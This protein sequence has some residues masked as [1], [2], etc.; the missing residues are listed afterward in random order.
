MF[1]KSQMISNFTVLQ[2]SQCFWLMKTWNCKLPQLSGM[3]SNTLRKSGAFSFSWCFLD[4]CDDWWSLL[5]IST[6]VWFQIINGLIFIQE[7]ITVIVNQYVHVVMHE[8]HKAFC[9][10]FTGR[11]VADSMKWGKYQTVILLISLIFCCHWKILCSVI[12]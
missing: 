11:H 3:V 6:K 1:P 7:A 5:M 10:L 2:P 4:C 8:P 9:L 12:S